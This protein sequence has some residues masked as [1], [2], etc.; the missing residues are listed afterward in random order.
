MLPLGE[1]LQ[2]YKGRDGRGQV[3]QDKVWGAHMCAKNEFTL[4]ICLLGEFTN[5]LPTDKALEALTTLIAWKADKDGI[6]IS[7][8]T[9]HP[10]GPSSYNVTASLGH[11]IG[12]KDG[13]Q[14]NYTQCPGTTLHAKI[15]DL[16]ASVQK[17]IDEKDCTIASNIENNLN[18]FKKIN[19]NNQNYWIP[20]QQFTSYSVHN[21][22]GQILYQ[23]NYDDQIQFLNIDNSMKIIQFRND[24]QTYTLK[25]KE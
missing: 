4:G 18:D 17:K 6:N 13:C 20:N 15:G 9:N 11:L 8:S 25:I 19:I 23:H 21:V 3:D 10:L 24:F 1:E 16:K 12:H 22:L 2:I 5:S 7:G 14:A